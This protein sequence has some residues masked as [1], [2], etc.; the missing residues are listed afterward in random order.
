MTNQ[1]PYN[2]ITTATPTWD[3]PT[4]SKVMHDLAALLQTELR[5]SGVRVFS[6]MQSWPG[7]HMGVG[8]VPL[9]LTQAGFE[10]VDLGGSA[11]TLGTR[12]TK[13]LTIAL[14]AILSS[15]QVP[16]P[17]VALVAQDLPLDV[18]RVIKRNM[19]LPDPE[20][21]VNQLQFSLEFTDHGLIDNFRYGLVD[22]KYALWRS[23]ELSIT[24]PRLIY[25][26]ANSNAEVGV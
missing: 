20:S 11:G 25:W 21:G 18:E 13:R 14:H 17:Q 5:S 4:P 26:M 22:G 3:A 12:V 8:D 6:E 2:P 16:L 10:A 15:A 23:R 7:A 1:W 9:L 24:C 19:F